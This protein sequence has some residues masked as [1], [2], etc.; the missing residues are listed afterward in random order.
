MYYHQM[1]VNI[2][3]NDTDVNNVLFWSERKKQEISLELK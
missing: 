1:T 3:A 2:P